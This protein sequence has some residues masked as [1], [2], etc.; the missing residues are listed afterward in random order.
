[1]LQNHS[2]FLW[3]YYLHQHSAE[4][5]YQ[6]GGSSFGSS[7]CSSAIGLKIGKFESIKGLSSFATN[8]FGQIHNTNCLLVRKIE[9]VIFLFVASRRLM[10]FN[11]WLLV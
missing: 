9:V 5:S 8:N 7:I 6:A 10:I 3:T 11:T 4:V 2:F 1:M